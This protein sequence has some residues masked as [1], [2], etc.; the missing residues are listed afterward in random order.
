VFLQTRLKTVIGPW[1]SPPLV[2]QHSGPVSLRQETRP[3]TET[4]SH[5][6]L[7]HAIP[8]EVILATS[9]VASILPPD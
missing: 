4:T 5:V 1:S 9:V 2:G 6:T 7:A 8:G 3:R